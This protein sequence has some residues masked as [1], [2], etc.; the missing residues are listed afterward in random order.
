MA[1]F[2]KREKRLGGDE[3]LWHIM[4]NHNKQVGTK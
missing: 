3:T 4:Q 2:I 1:R